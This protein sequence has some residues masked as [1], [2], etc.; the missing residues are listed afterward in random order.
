M[1]ERNSYLSSY[2]TLFNKHDQNYMANNLIEKLGNGIN[3]VI[4][5]IA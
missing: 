2:I 3:N 1:S 5:I 4:A